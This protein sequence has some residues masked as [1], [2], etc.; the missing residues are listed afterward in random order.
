MLSKAAK[1]PRRIWIADLLVVT[2]L[3]G[4]NAARLSAHSGAATGAALRESIQASEH[5]VEV[6]PRS[7]Q[8]GDRARCAGTLG[9]W[10]SAFHRQL[11]FQSKEW[12]PGSRSCPDSACNTVGVCNRDTGV[13][14][15]MAGWTGVNCTERQSR[16]CTNKYRES[17]SVPQG[18]PKSWSEPGWT[19]SRC[20]GVCDEDIAAC[21]CNG[22]RG[23]IPAAP[24][25]PAGALPIQQGRPMILDQC[26]P[27]RDDAGE[28]VEHGRLAPEL[29]FGP[30][31]WCEAEEP[32]QSCGCVVDGQTGPY[33][34][35]PLEHTCLNQCSGH[36]QCRFGF[37]LCD[38]GFYG[39]DCARHAAGADMSTDAILLEKPWI[40]EVVTNAAVDVTQSRPQLRP[41]IYVYD[42]PSMYNTRML[43]YRIAKNT[44]LWRSFEGT[45]ITAL[46]Q[47]SHYSLESLLHEHLLQSP[48]R[49]L[50]PEEADFFY[51]PVYTSCYV[52]PVHGWADG[53][54]WY[55]PSG[56]R[57]MHAA[58]MLLEAKQWLQ[59]HLPYWNR[60][61]GKDH[62]W[63]VTHDE[64]SCWVPSEI[65]PSIILS[66]WGRKDLNHTSGSAYLADDYSAEHIHPEYSPRGWLNIIQGHPCYDPE[67]DLVVPS[68][69]G[70]Q[71]IGPS[72]LLGFPAHERRHLLFFRGEVGHQ[73][74]A[75]YSR[76]IRQRLY[77]LARS[78]R[79]KQRLGMMVG[80]A[81]D[82]AEGGSYERM[83]SSSKFC[84]VAPGDGWSGRAEDSIL[85]G[86]IPVVIMDDVDPVFATA[87][88]WE[89]FSI[90]VR[91]ADMD[92]LDDILTAIPAERVEQMQRAL[93][94]VWQ[95]FMYRSFP[96]FGSE[97]LATQDI[98][99]RMYHRA[100]S[101][102]SL[103][104]PVTHFRDDDDAFAT[105]IQW[106]YS[107]C[108]DRSLTASI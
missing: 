64:G 98:H 68:F 17:G 28:P 25:S 67:K 60:T 3:C 10:C 50:D 61:G 12:I 29:I 39:H 66:H 70:P 79:W 15:C 97:L 104:H 42:L 99:D 77:T 45:N 78:R 93:S 80:T 52:H 81:H 33:C 100:G 30:D 62:V 69:L 54:W 85:H 2:L 9:G 58:N 105:I 38:E 92:R 95:R 41:L 8:A 46:T 96:Y 49:T 84:L 72:P 1:G 21:Y 47:W 6:E 102:T 65:R 26:Q 11:T 86:C 4:T 89:R 24:G 107:K 59:T 82:G 13:C 55:G 32:E 76:S 51:V 27:N 90:R 83:L 103:P 56:P 57:V 18:A 106:L 7:H 74:L 5:L 14:D 48:H 63:L 22:T 36:G 73:R 20:A 108:I 23:H 88:H 94:R 53:P 91:E 101:N 40:A 31:G 71:R 19:A 44:C 75:H 37:C 43:Q 87:L 35:E 16:P 34:D